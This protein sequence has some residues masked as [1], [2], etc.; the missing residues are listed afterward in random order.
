MERTLRL[1]HPFMPFITE[2]LWQKLAPLL[3]KKNAS[4]MLEPYPTFDVSAVDTE[5][6]EH[7][8][9]LK[10][11]IIVVRNIRGELD[12]SPAKTINIMLRNG[13]SKDRA[14]LEKYRP[15]LQKLAKLEN[16]AW[17]AKEDNGPAAATQLYKKLEILVPLEG[18]IDVKA[19]RTRLAKEI[20][21]LELGLSKVSSK[22]NNEKFARNA[23]PSVVAKE[24]E[25]QN[26]MTTALSSLQSQLIQLEKL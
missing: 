9:W 10:G 21:K 16:I 26:Y 6:E 17:L 1:L 11:I 19:E 8:A 4:I 23:A 15:Y 14:R 20:S 13:D 18:L 7:I 2:E 24:K 12:I 25:K 3:G 5:A 22:L